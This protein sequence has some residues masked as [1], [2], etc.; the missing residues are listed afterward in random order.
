ME[1]P[2]DWTI[3]LSIGQEE[4]TQQLKIIQSHS[5]QHCDLPGLRL[6]SFDCDAHSR[7]V[8]NFTRLSFDNLNQELNDMV[9]QVCKAAGA[10][11][12]H[13]RTYSF[14]KQGDL[15]IHFGRK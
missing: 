12:Y 3:S 1:S 2:A 15:L 10:E 5:D 7:L 6:Q 14:N 11:E 4:G 9:D 8:E 13:K